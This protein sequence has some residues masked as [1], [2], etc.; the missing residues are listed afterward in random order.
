MFRRPIPGGG[1]FN[2]DMAF[3]LQKQLRPRPGPTEKFFTARLSL[4]KSF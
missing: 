2:C 3:D 4:D 1:D